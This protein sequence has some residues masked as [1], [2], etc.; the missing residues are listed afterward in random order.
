MKI[1]KPITS[2]EIYL[3]EDSEIISTTDLKGRIETANEEFVSISGFEHNEIIGNNHNMVRH[4]EMPPEAFA[5]LWQNNKANKPWMG[6][7]KNR[8]KNG[9]YYWVDAYVRPLYVDG[10]V[11][12]IGR[13][14]CRERV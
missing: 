12:E 1:N 6:L 5:D 10:V 9:D 2:K 3:E 4:P 14:S 13:A 7:V 11:T 8:C